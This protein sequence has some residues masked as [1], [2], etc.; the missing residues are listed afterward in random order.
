[1]YYLLRLQKSFDTREI[2]KRVKQLRKDR[3]ITQDE[4]GIILGDKT[5]GKPLSRGQVS[6]LETGKRNFNI[7]QIKALADYFRI[8]IETLG[9]ESDEIETIDL[10]ERAKL[11]FESELVPMEEKQDLYDSIMKLYLSAKDQFKK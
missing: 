1:M 9:F 10:L 6:N 5:T 4:L 11:I 8:S 2:G 3:N 7:H